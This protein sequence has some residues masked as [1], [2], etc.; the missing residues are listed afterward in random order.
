MIIGYLTRNFRARFSLNT[1][2][3]VASMILDFF[4]HQIILLICFIIGVFLFVSTK[5][6]TLPDQDSLL[7]LTVVVAWIIISLL[8]PLFKDYFNGQ[9][10]AKMQL[11]I[12]IVDSASKQI[13]TP[14]QCF[15]R[16]LTVLI[17]PIEFFVL[18]KNPNTR[19]GDMIAKTEVVVYSPLRPSNYETKSTLKWFSFFVVCIISVAYLLS[20]TIYDGTSIHTDYD[21]SSFDKRTSTIM[22]NKLEYSVGDFV[23][24][25][26]AKFYQRTKSHTYGYFIATAF[27]SGEKLD[28]QSR[29]MLIDSVKYS[30]FDFNL[31]N[32]C[33]SYLAIKYLNPEKGTI[34]YTDYINISSTHRYVDDTRYKYPNDSTE[35]VTENYMNGKKKSQTTYVKG[36]VTGKSFEWYSNGQIKSEISYENGVRTGITTEYD[37]EGNITARLLY[38][39]NNYVKDVD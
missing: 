39:N 14:L 20:L 30:I 38:E 34:R 32:R 9:S 37:I 36:K 10:I 35:V 8:I 6:N 3:R 1:G 33:A 21:V 28:L 24:S 26:D 4:Y 17:F 11:N 16:N 23:D 18:L 7:Q 19:L 15:I 5:G 29:N 12:Q 22:Q 2:T 25:I 13:A 31:K 27:L